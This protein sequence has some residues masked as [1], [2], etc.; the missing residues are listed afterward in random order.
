MALPTPAS[1][2]V[3]GAYKLASSIDD[4]SAQVA[5]DAAALARR[6]PTSGRYT[7][8]ANTNQIRYKQPV[9]VLPDIDV[10][11]V[12]RYLVDYGSGAHTVQYTEPMYWNGRHTTY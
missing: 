2:A 4:Q 9:E 10:H 7:T 8:T 5:A 6:Y 12:P 11:G 3:Y 1:L